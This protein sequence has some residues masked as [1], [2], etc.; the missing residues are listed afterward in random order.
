M[1]GHAADAGVGGR[2]VVLVEIHIVETAAEQRRGV[3][4][5][6][7]ES[8]RLHVAVAGEQHAP[9]FAHRKRIRRVVE[10][11][12]AMG[13]VLPIRVCGGVAASTVVVS[14]EMLWFDESTSN[15]ASERRLESGL[16]LGAVVAVE[17]RDADQIP[18]PPMTTAEGADASAHSPA[19]RSPRQAMQHEQPAGRQRRYYMRPVRHRAQGRVAQFQERHAA[20]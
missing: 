4:A 18:A 12:E 1:A 9:R 11:R 13:A 17:G 10:R 2:I 16:P 19:D 6:G 20:R 14:H 8:R 3:V 7:A 15:G 5:A